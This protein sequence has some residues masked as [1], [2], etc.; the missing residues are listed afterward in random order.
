MTVVQ[1]RFHAVVFDA[2]V[3]VL[4]RVDKDLLTSFLVLG[5]EFV[6]A[7]SA[8]G[9]IG[10]KDR[11][12]LFIWQYIG[13]HICRVVDAP[14]DDRLVRVAL[15]KI[16]LD[17][18]SDTWNEH[19]TPQIARQWLGNPQPARA[20]GVG[21]TVAVPVKLHFYA[22]IFICKDLL[23]RRADHERGLGAAD[24]WF[25]RLSRRTI[26]RPAGTVLYAGKGRRVT[27]VKNFFGYI[28]RRLHCFVVN[29]GQYIRGVVFRDRVVL[30]FERVPGCQPAAVSRA[31][32]EV[33][34]YVDL[35][36]AYLCR[37]GA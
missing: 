14:R 30:Q 34:I 19:R 33:V 6:K 20:A 4:F 10:F 17:L 7:A 8:L 15:Q 37:P 31:D 29:A 26:R 21:G 28:S 36:L 11:L 3:Y 12:C 23:A 24:I 22:S 27:V 32:I 9:R 1:Y 35:L 5:P 25:S 2:D 13:R 18:H 16:N